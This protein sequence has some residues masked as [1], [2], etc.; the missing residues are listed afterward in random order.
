MC[1]IN[2]PKFPCSICAKN[3]NN[4]DKAVHCELDEFW[5]HIKCNNH[6]YL[7]YKHLLNYD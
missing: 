4:K 5:I 7:D 2:A 1:N 3:V 6:N